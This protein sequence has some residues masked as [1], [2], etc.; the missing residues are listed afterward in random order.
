MPNLQGEKNQ[1]VEKYRV[2]KSL[3]PTPF[4]TLLGMH[5][6]KFVSQLCCHLTLLKYAL[7]YIRVT[8]MTEEIM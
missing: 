6:R 4:I 1:S 8:E 7:T 3:P 2:F 5:A